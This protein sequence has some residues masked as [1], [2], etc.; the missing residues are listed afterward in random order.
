MGGIGAQTADAPLPSTG[1]TM[2]GLIDTEIRIFGRDY[3]A[4]WYKCIETGAWRAEAS[5]A[6]VVV[7]VVDVPRASE[8]L[9][10]LVK[11]LA[12]RRRR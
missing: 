9:A 2:D 3:R 11:F 1:D 4:C 7:A 5:I 8:T 12:Q 10:S 6:G